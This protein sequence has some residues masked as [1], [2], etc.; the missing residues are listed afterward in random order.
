MKLTKEEVERV[1]KL[2]SF[3]RYK[4]FMKRVIDDGAMYSLRKAADWA[5]SDLKSYK[6]FSLWSAEAYTEEILKND[7]DQYI[8]FKIDFNFFQ[9]E[10]IPFIKKNNFLVN[11]FCVNDK[12]GFL[13]ELDEFIRDLIDEQ[14]GV[15]Y[16]Y[17]G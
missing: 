6:V 17:T 11:V 4:Y 15:N 8:P 16:R 5:I 2:D 10:I 14:R 9:D 12:P 7:W 1:L 3:T 13:V